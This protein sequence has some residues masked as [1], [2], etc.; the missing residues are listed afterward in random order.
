MRKPTFTN[1]SLF[2]SIL[3]MGTVILA[4]WTM[5]ARAQVWIDA[6]QLGDR[7]P[8]WV[9]SKYYKPTPAPPAVR[10]IWV[11]PVYRI[12]CKR[13]WHEPVYQTVRDR[14]WVE[15]HYIVSTD[16][17][18]DPCNDP[19]V[20]YLHMPS[21]VWVPGHYETIERRICVS[22]G[23]WESMRYKELITPAHWETITCG[24]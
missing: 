17:S 9:D 4:G 6:S 3:V 16:V 10:M 19:S 11:E 22:P 21:H 23:Y 20:R 14:I 7:T 18:H 15:G 12:V 2:T 5:P 1:C 13:I 8:E 24:D